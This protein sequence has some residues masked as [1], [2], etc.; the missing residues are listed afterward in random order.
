MSAVLKPSPFPQVARKK[1]T[2]AEYID[3]SL[4]TVEH[5]TPMPEGRRVIGKYDAKFASLK[6]GS[7][8]A[9][10]PR[11]V[12]CVANALRKWLERE[13]APGKVES[14][15]EMRDGKGRVWLQKA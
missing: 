5:N 8:I 11:E 13:K 7:C 2:K 9:C 12:N 15:R 10:E 3:P 6:Y 4:L 1:Q 14:A